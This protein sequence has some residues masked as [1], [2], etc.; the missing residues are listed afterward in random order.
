MIPDRLLEINAWVVFGF[1]GQ[2]FFTLRFL[3][4]WVASERAGRS[5]V[6]VFFWYLSILGGGVLFVYALWYRHD[7]VFTLG[8][9]AGLFVYTRNLILIRRGRVGATTEAVQGAPGPGA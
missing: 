3:V 6:P 7:P 8:Q 1:L 4:Q 2:L 5:T 9:G